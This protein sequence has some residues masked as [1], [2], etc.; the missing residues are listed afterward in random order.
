MK[1]VRCMSCFLCSLSILLCFGSCAVPDS[2]AASVADSSGSDSSAFES[3][4]VQYIPL[5]KLPK[6][7]FGSF[8]I[9]RDPVTDVLYL[10]SKTGSAGGLTVMLD[11]VSGSPLTYQRYLELYKR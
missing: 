8:S 1:F 6:S 4:L 11:P 10:A 9:H 5:E 3:S 7:D 2:S